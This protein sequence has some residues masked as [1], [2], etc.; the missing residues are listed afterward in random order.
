MF[1]IRYDKQSKYSVITNGNSWLEVFY[2]PVISSLGSVDSRRVLDHL[3]RENI[4]L[5][6]IDE[7][8][9]SFI[10]NTVLSTSQAEH[11]TAEEKEDIANSVKQDL[12]K[13]RDNRFSHFINSFTGLPTNKEET[14]KFFGIN[15]YRAIKNKFKIKFIGSTLGVIAAGI[16]TAV[17]SVL[18]AI[19]TAV[20]IAYVIPLL[21]IPH[22]IKNIFVKN[23]ETLDKQSSFKIFNTVAKAINIA[24][25][26]V[27]NI[28]QTILRPIGD[29]F[30]S[31]MSAYDTGSQ[32]FKSKNLGK[33]LAVSSIIFS[34]LGLI[35]LSIATAGLFGASKAGA[36]AVKSYSTAASTHAHS[37]IINTIIHWAKH[38]WRH[39]LRI[40]HLHGA[41]IPGSGVAGLTKSHVINSALSSSWQMV[42]RVVYRQII[43]PIRNLFRRPVVEKIPSV[44][45]PSV[46]EQARHSR[47]GGN[48]AVINNEEAGAFFN[49]LDSRLRGNDGIHENDG[50]HGRGD[51]SP[52]SKGGSAE[53]AGV[54]T[55]PQSSSE[56]TPLHRAALPPVRSQGHVL[57]QTFDSPTV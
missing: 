6:N 24:L 34:T 12:K 48:P 47:E 5:N 44:E 26:S 31:A 38:L 43:L 28:V 1:S 54:F 57:Q 25:F 10:I 13:L 2:T 39:L 21:I 15:I 50:I 16:N 29:P 8:E 56:C 37:G 49:E 23:L 42:S 53:G 30:Y 40:S 51:H 18:T 41:L 17:R 7:I 27:F 36:L 19:Y 55:D 46:E 22:L 45:I 14:N 4:K 3:E 32:S 35:G 11:L 33:I 20:N 52:L 9:T